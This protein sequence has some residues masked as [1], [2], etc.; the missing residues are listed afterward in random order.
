[1][2]LIILTENQGERE[3]GHL[4]LVTKILTVE[5]GEGSYVSR[6]NDSRCR[7]RER[8]RPFVSRNYNF[9]LSAVQ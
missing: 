1:M 8:G 5:A 4:S 2:F 3:R 6:N 9:I 7:L